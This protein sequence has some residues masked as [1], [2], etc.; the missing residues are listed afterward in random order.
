M[1]DGQERRLAKTFAE[2]GNLVVHS[3]RDVTPRYAPVFMGPMVSSSKFGTIGK[4]KI[5]PRVAIYWD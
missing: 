3:K 5:D 1:M 2:L 4:K